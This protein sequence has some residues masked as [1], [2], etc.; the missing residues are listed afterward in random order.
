MSK[1][2]LCLQALTLP[3]IAHRSEVPRTMRD[4]FRALRIVESD[5]NPYAVGDYGHALG[6]YQITYP[7]W[8]DACDEQ[9]DL[10]FGSYG[11]CVYR[12]YS[13]NVMLAYWKRHAPDSVSWEQ[14]AR[15]HNGGPNGYK[16]QAT[17][18]YWK[19]VQRHLFI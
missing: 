11:M 3:K 12:P 4:L 17:R 14:L 5:C 16:K 13:E 9:P 15:I 18:P 6:M 19:K 2:A 1:I 8:Q 7:Y 10:R